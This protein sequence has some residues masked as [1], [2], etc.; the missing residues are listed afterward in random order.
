MVGI[1]KFSRSSGILLH[2]TSLPGKFGIGSLGNEA[3]EFI[4]FL[5]EA[6]QKIW[7]I[8]PTGPTGYGDSPYQT[9]SAFA[10]NPL[11]I[12]LEELHTEGLIE[13]NHLDL[14]E[15][16][17]N[18]QV[19]F[20]RVIKFKY[21]ILRIAYENFKTTNE[22]ESF[23]EQEKYW[24]DDF[25]LFMALKQHF[26]G[27]SWKEWDKKLKTRDLS[28]LEDYR[29]KLK[30]NINFNIFLQY[31]FFKQW[32]KVREYANSRNIK[33]F[34]D[35]PIF[36]AFDSSDAWSNPDIFLL[37]EE[38]NPIVVAGVPPDFFSETGQLWGNPL[39]NWEVLEKK[40][41]K[42]WIQRVKA[43]LKLVDIV[44][45]DHF[46]G[47]A[48]YWAVPYEEKTAIKGTWEKAPGKKLFTILQNKLGELPIVAED[49]GVITDDVTE[50][51]DS[52]NFPGMKILQFAF[53]SGADNPFLPHNFTE[54]CVVYTGTHDNDT[55]LG[56]YKKLP[57]KEKNYLLEYLQFDGKNICWKL[58]ETAWKSKADIA[59]APMQD[60]LCLDSYAR[61]NTPAVASG[62]WQWRVKKDQLNFELAKRIRNLTW[63]S[64]R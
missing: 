6:G 60:F 57:E 55:T 61:M 59:I 32:E 51:R 41:F 52:F 25:S 2:I 42:W 4:D 31:I 21:K 8:L 47:F 58:I 15:E 22:Y 45:I 14:L 53:G 29:D 48:G 20:G 16:S 27:K 43:A 11:L 64:N 54:N 18:E 40:D 10:G 13:H 36:V 3:F 39:Y 9:F 63:D 23:C 62:N 50:L 35:L 37:D 1:M 33:I 46:R 17:N 44:R 49:L 24:L 38:K 19:D 26:E 30:E 12:D 56:W 7:Q 28:V 34:G 5:S